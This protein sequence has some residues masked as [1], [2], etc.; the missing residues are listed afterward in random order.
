MNISEIKDILNKTKRTQLGIPFLPVQDIVEL[1]KWALEGSPCEG[2]QVWFSFQDVVA[3]RNSLSPYIRCRI[4]PLTNQQVDYWLHHYP[5]DSLLLE[6]DPTTR[7][8]EFWKSRGSY[9]KHSL[10]TTAFSLWIWKPNTSPLQMYG[11]DHHHAVLWDIKQILRPLGVTVDF[12]WL[13]DGREPVNEAIPSEDPPFYSSLDIY[14]KPVEICVD[15]EFQAKLKKK[16][17]AIITAHSLVTGYR[18]HTVDLPQF[19]I[20][21]TRFGND[22]IQDPKRHSILVTTLQEMLTKKKLTVV[23]NNKGDCAYFHQYFHVQ[24]QQELILPSICEQISRK[25]F[26]VVTPMKFLI[27]DTRQVLLNPKGSPFMK[28]F[29]QKCQERFPGQIDSQAILLAQNQHYLPEGYLDSY[30]AIIHFP[31]NVST[32]SIFEQTAAN[33]PIWIPSATLLE[34]LWTDPQEPNELSWTVFAEGSE[35]NASPMDKVRDPAVVK[36]WIQLSDF[37]TKPIS[38]CI[39]SFDSI[40]DLLDRIFTVNYKESIEKNLESFHRRQENTIAS[41]E[42]LLDRC[43]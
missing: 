43:R 24:P 34:S 1:F 39:F 28:R 30:T 40:E 37:Y 29:Y 22:W 11:I 6:E 25:R 35:G 9:E 17:D 18:L 8:T 2:R 20:N 27:W 15:E 36:Q 32:M 19:H 12:V 5:S 4:L 7:L 41:W 38:D 13:C 16:Y 10:S 33:I 26:S 14:R 42:L 3:F 31:Y 21:S 23:H